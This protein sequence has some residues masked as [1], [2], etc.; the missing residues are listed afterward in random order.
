MKIHVNSKVLLL[1]ESQEMEKKKTINSFKISRI[2]LFNNS[3]IQDNHFTPFQIP[4][5]FSIE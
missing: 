2:Q 4:M 1:Y 3:T 5:L